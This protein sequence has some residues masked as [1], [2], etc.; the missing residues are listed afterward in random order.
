M[1]IVIPGGSGHL[2]KALA[3]AFV[4]AGHE[5]VVLS[6]SPRTRPGWREVAWDGVSIGPWAGEVDGADAVVNLAGRSVNCRYTKAN[7]KEMMDSRV[8]STRAVGLA[9]ARAGRPPAVWLQMSTATLYAHTFG[10]ANDEASGVIGGAEPGVPALWRRSIEIAKA[11]EAAQAEADTPRTR[12]VTLRSA[13]VM[14]REAGGVF[15]LL[16]RLARFGLGGPLAGGAQ[17]MSWIHERDFVRAVAFLIARAD[18]SGPF[19]L[20]SPNPLPQREFM[21][22]VRAAGGHRLALPATRWMLEIGTFLLRTETELILKSRRVVPARL[23]EAGFRF[24]H[25]EW[26]AAA[27]DLLQGSVATSPLRPPR[28]AA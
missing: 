26:P 8:E 12:K 2:G 3:D 21:A 18:L 11:W 14:G 23:L 1:K 7:L 16:A 10:A 25:P 22:A 13:M 9:I 15:D 28:P 17:F 27:R 24:E 4:A 5:V 6:R 19:N 20:A